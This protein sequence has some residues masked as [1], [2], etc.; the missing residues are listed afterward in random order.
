MWAPEAQRAQGRLCKGDLLPVR[1]V[2]GGVVGALEGS[3]VEDC[4]KIV[5]LGE[6]CCWEEEEGEDN[7]EE[8]PQGGC[9]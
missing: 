3:I 4:Q 2:V 8:Q 9:G 7:S 5:L 6:C 1:D